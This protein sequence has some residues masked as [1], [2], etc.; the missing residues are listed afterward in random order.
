MGLLGL[1]FSFGA[2]TLAMRWLSSWLEKG[3]WGWFGIYCIV[4]A[5]LIIASKWLGVLV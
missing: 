4:V 2:G 1:I 5:V 3:R